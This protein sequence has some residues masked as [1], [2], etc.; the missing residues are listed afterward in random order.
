LLAKLTVQALFAEPEKSRLG[1][2]ALGGSEV[3]HGRHVGPLDQAMV[4]PEADSDPHAKSQEPVKASEKQGV[5]KMFMHGLLLRA[6]L[7]LCGDIAY[8]ER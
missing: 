3:Q 6:P 8:I 1:H 2:K 5:G 4:E 7:D